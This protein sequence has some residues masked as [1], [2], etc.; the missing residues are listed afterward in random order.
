LGVKKAYYKGFKVNKLIISLQTEFST[1][2][3]VPSQFD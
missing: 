1:V 3:L 2:K